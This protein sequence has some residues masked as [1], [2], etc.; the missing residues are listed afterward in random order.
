[1]GGQKQTVKHRDSQQVKLPSFLTSGMEGLTS[2]HRCRCMLEPSGWA[3]WLNQ[4]RK[5]KDKI[6]SCSGMKLETETIF[7]ASL[8]MLSTVLLGSLVE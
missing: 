1:M 7:G 3:P 5:A 4:N 2:L 6:P 8:F